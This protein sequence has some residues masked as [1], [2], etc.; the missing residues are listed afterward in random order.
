MCEQALAADRPLD[1]LSTLLR[2]RVASGES[3][4][5]LLAELAGLRRALQLEGR[6]QD[7][8]VVLEAMDFLTGF[9]SPHL[10]I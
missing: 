10:R 4:E 8:D 7:E 3:R 6:D 9:C 1:C 2:K 5:T